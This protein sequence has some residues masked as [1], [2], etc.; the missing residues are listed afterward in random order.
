MSNSD[1]DNI[2]QVSALA[3]IL[4]EAS[5]VHFLEDMAPYVMVN[6]DAS[7]LGTPAV[8]RKDIESFVR[9]T[10]PTKVVEKLETISNKT[11]EDYPRF[12]FGAGDD[13][14]YSITTDEFAYRC[15]YKMDK[16][17]VTL[18]IRRVPKLS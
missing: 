10:A 18:I 9:N 17:G 4:G 1:I 7:R 8:S 12:G 13:L 11:K 15:H 2:P 5:T 14:L 16:Q 3:E 6:G